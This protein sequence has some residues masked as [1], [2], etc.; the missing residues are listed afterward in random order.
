MVRSRIAITAL[1]AVAILL[2]AAALHARDIH[3]GA[4]SERQFTCS[5]SIRKSFANGHE[6]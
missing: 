1:S 5:R 4:S 2:L 6:W 3:L